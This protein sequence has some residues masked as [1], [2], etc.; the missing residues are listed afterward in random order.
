MGSVS[1]L[2][3]RNPN[4]IKRTIMKTL[5]IFACLLA[6]T[7]AAEKT[8][9][10]QKAVQLIELVD[11]VSEEQR[12][13]GFRGGRRGRSLADETQELEGQEQ[14]YGGYRGG[15]GGRRG[16]SVAEETQEVEGQEQ[17]YGVTVEDMVV[18]VGAPLLKRLKK[19]KDKNRDMEDTVE[20]MV[21]VAMAAPSLMRPK[22]WKDRNRDM[23]DT[24]EDTVAVA[25]AALLLMRP[26]NW[27]DRSRGMED[28]AEDMVVA[29]MGALSKLTEFTIL[30]ADVHNEKVTVKASP[31]MPRLL[32]VFLPNKSPCMR[33]L[34]CLF[35]SFYT[36]F[37]I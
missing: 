1:L 27:K 24:V 30:M 34:N 9:E 12:Y 23:E 26:K 29:D 14:R 10:E 7:L 6:V 5:T 21:V 20:E 16:R 32:A 33:T 17:R 8:A 22:N 4:P 37:L 2:K 11:Q 3:Q 28:I 31:S 13:G 25:M 35:R 36:D 15:Y 18:V 19:L